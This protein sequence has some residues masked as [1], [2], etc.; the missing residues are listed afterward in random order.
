MQV[1]AFAIILIVGIVISIVKISSTKKKREER[2]RREQEKRDAALREAQRRVQEREKQNKPQPPRPATQNRRAAG[3]PFPSYKVNPFEEKVTYASSLSAAQLNEWLLD[4]AAAE[5]AGA[6]RPERSKIKPLF[7]RYLLENDFNYRL[8]RKMRGYT[9][10]NRLQFAANVNKVKPQAV[11]S[12]YSNDHISLPL[13]EQKLSP[14]AYLRQKTVTVEL[15]KK[16]FRE[17]RELYE[18]FYL[19]KD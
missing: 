17:R 1:F 7:V 10:Q 9:P 2:D 4:F 13:P 19:N 18:S 5:K 12:S 16:N 6:R 11:D 14:S 15:P 8:L 3:D